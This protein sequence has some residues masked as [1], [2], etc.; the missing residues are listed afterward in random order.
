VRTP[1]VL[2]AVGIV[3]ALGRDCAE[4]AARLFAGDQSGIRKKRGFI[5]E[6]ECFVGAVDD[7]LPASPKGLQHLWS[8][9]AAL[10]LIALEQI[11]VP[12]Q[13]TIKRYGA[14]RVGVVL[15]SSTSGIDQGELALR[16]LV[17]AGEL[18]SSY[19]YRQQQMGTVSQ[20][21]GL[22]SGALGPNYTIS[23]A[24]SSSAKVFRAAMNL[25]HAGLCDS[26]ITGGFD[27]LCKLT[28]NGFSALELVSDEVTN[29]FS[30]NRKGISI[31]EGGAL[32]LL[33]RAT[34]SALHSDSVCICGVGESSDAYHISSP[35]PEAK[36]AIAAIRKAIEHAGLHA[37]DIDYVNL[38]GTGTLHN[39]A[40][41]SRAVRAVFGESIPCSSTK[42]LVGHM[43]GAS[44]ATEVAFCWMALRDLSR[45][46][47]P[48]RFDGELDPE[49]PR[50]HFV[51]IG[52]TAAQPLRFA[53]S[54][55]FGFGGSNCAIVIG[56]GDCVTP[57]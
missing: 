36:G 53:L 30:K 28:L 13:E 16:A 40:M 25:I 1:V 18:P 22:L 31:G 2:A 3:N 11:Q 43:L 29:P 4:V 41:E 5:P 10:S 50:M 21:I 46:L 45:R 14:S 15:G 39:D 54:N 12:V 57:R 32:F 35:D 19:S 55:S 38:H 26:V 48:H 23:T 37:A 33:E 9:N 17:R 52:E 42:P 34:P 49:L 7:P 27:S 44:G 24:C 6:R 20:T 51:S 56:R 47:P 8:R